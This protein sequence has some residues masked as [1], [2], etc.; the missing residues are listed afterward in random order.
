MSKKL[1]IPRLETLK[2]EALENIHSY[3]DPESPMALQQFTSKMKAILLDDPS[4]LGSLPEYL[5]IALYGQVKFPPAATTQWQQ[6]LASATM[7]T[8]DQFKT[9]VAFNNADLPFVKA[10]RDY[11]E[12]VLIEACA[13]VFMINQDTNTAINYDDADEHEDD[14]QD[15]DYDSDYDDQ[16]GDSD[17]EGYDD[18]FDDIGFKGEDA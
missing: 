4:M 14:Y 3:D 9:S 13:V 15:N 8:W 16:S 11:S 6:W 12:S 5:P 10:I 17:E 18:Q 7:P 1:N 2:T